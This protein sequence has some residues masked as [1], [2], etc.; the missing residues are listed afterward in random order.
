MFEDK[1]VTRTWENEQ[2]FLKEMVV[3]PAI[4]I[5]EYRK[6]QKIADEMY[7]YLVQEWCWHCGATLQRH[8]KV[9]EILDKYREAVDGRLE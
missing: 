8:Y 7:K 3:K 5:A 1:P 9:D 2:E 4:N 6:W